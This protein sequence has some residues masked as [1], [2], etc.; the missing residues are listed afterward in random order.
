[1]CM[2]MCG[3]HVCMCACANIEVAILSKIQSMHV[4]KCSSFCAHETYLF[5]VQVLVHLGQET[6]D[7][8]VRVVNTVKTLRM[9]EGH[10]PNLILPLP[11]SRLRIKVNLSVF[12]HIVSA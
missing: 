4:L 7:Y 10:P 12:D 9:Q 11:D 8:S 6:K 3:V 1:M 5:Y 2:C